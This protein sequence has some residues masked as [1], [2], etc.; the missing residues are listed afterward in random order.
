MAE[1]TANPFRK[2]FSAIK[3]L[4]LRHRQEAR[5]FRPDHHIVDPMLAPSEY[6][7]SASPVDITTEDNIR[8]HLWVKQPDSNKPLFIFFHGNTGHFGDVG[9][10]DTGEEYDPQYR[11][12][13]LK[14]IEKKA[15]YIAVS[16]RGYG[17]SDKVASTEEGFV[18]DTR[19][20]INYA[21]DGLKTPHQ[22]VIL[23]GE[24]LGA[25]VA[26][27]AAEEMTI[28][29]RPP[30]MV[31]IIAAFSSMK[32][33]V[34]ELHPDLSPEAVERSL[35]HKFDSEERI[36]KL[37]RDTSF[38]IAHPGD[39]EVTLKDHSRKLTEIAKE[40]GL[41]VTYEELAGGHITWE[42]KQVV[43]GVL[44]R[45]YSTISVG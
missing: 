42:P 45:Y 1:R 6:G 34:I 17:V 39:D 9:Q 11:I 31:A 23:A 37:G 36:K 25:A 28:M 12:N 44:E 7:L 22:R 24:S 8:I 40:A 10:P 43:D 4:Y 15:G 30:A 14:E 41:D 35:R 13:L 5:I 16:L 2:L 26:M 19:A 20:V 29:D 3:L 38:Y 27:I 18:K 32:W 33:K 21:L